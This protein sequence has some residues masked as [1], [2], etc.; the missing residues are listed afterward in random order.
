MYYRE[1]AALHERY[2]EDNTK[3]EKKVIKG[4]TFD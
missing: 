3:S 1:T 2:E 4:L